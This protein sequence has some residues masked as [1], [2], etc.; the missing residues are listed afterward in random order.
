MAQL[1]KLGV[2]DT[3]TNQKLPLQFQGCAFSA[4]QFPAL[5]SHGDRKGVLEVLAKDVSGTWRFKK[6][7]WYKLKEEDAKTISVYVS[8]YYTN[9]QSE[10]KQAIAYFVEDEG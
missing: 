10:A 9:T 4:V 5:A 1:R 7:R 6:N 3:Y 8:R 2:R